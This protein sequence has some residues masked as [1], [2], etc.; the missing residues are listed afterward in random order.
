IARPVR[1]FRVVFDHDGSNVLT[2]PEPVKQVAPSKPRPEPD[3]V[4]LAFWESVQAS[5]DQREYG[6]YLRQFPDGAFAGLA[7]S[8]LERPVANDP[9]I[10][11]AFWD[12]VKDTND[13]H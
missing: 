7:R 3:P 1:A 4:E 11:L 9:T 8:R 2:R 6:E 12:S 13:P 10:E 5:D